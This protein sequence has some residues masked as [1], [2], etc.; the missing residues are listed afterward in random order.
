MY[1]DGRGTNLAKQNPQET[2]PNQRQKTWANLR[3]IPLR[4][5]LE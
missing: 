5:Q 2:L 4:F 1:I 3:A